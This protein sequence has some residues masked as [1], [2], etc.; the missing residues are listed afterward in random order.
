MPGRLLVAAK[1]AGI[2][3]FQNGNSTGTANGRFSNNAEYLSPQLPLTYEY[4]EKW[5]LSAQ[6]AGAVL[7][8]NVLAAPSVSVG[9]HVKL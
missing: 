8:R 5:G 9:V 2:A 6:V 3:S 7:G 1:V 4:R